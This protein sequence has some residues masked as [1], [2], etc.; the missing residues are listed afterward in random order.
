[1]TQ[2]LGKVKTQW[3]QDSIQQAPSVDV[4]EKLTLEREQLILSYFDLEPYWDTTETNS[5]I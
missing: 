4:P 2:E 5:S 1:E 3:R